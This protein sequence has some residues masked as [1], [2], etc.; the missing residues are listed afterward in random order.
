MCRAFF[1]LCASAQMRPISRK[2]L[3]S[4]ILTGEP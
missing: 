4:L 2:A 3:C 1:K